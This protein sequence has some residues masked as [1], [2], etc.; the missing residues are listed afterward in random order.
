[1]AAVVVAGVLLLGPLVFWEDARVNPLMSTGW[2]RAMPIIKFSKLARA[3]PSSANPK[4]AP[5]VEVTT[6]GAT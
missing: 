2:S 4:G 6:C 3:E 5:A 1:M